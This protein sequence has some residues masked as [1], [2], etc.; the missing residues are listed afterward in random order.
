MTQLAADQVNAWI[1]KNI[2]R[3]L[4]IE[5]SNSTQVVIK[6]GSAVG[7]DDGS[8]VMEAGADITVDIT[9]SGVNGLDQGSEA[10]DTWY[11]IYMIWNPSTETVAGLLSASSSNPTLPSGYDKKRLVGAVRNDGSSNFKHFLQRG[12][13]VTASETVFSTTWQTNSWRTY[14][15]SSLVPVMTASVYY[16]T[17]QYPSNGSEASWGVFAASPDRD[18]SRMTRIGSVD[19]S[20]YYATD[21]SDRHSTKY[22]SV[23]VPIVNQTLQV[24]L[25]S[26]DTF[27]PARNCH[28]RVS[29]YTI[30]L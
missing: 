27:T 25:H 14:S 5:C 21:G 8:I 22:L 7:A 11:Y 2:I 1:A 30:D 3:N 24:Y 28:V 9:N 23:L 4:H 29:G 12:N 20:T 17:Y 18:T 13:L 26:S 19:T 6:Q 16:D 15:L 10:S